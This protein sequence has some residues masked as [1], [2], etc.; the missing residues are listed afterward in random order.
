MKV[1]VTG[2]GGFLGCHI[3]ALLQQ[4]GYQVRVMS[5]SRQPIFEPRGIECMRG[6]ISYLEEVEAA[7]K[8]MD[9]V[10]NVAGRASID[11][12]YQAYYNTHVIGAKNIVRACKRFGVTRL[13]HTSTP[14]VVFNGKDLSGG[15]ESLPNQK[16]YH[17]YY[18]STK[19][20]AEEYILGCNSEDLRTVALRPHLILGEGDPH[21][22]PR[23][24]ESVRSGEFRMI[25][26]GKNW[27]D[28]TFVSN[29]AHAHLLAFDALDTGK[30]CGKAY[31]IGQERPI[32]LW[33]FINTILSHLNLP[34]VTKRVS[35]GK[36]YGVGMLMEC[37]YKTFCRSRMPPM[38]RALAVALSHDH[39]FSHER[40]RND[41]GY[42]PP[43]TIEQGLTN[44]VNGLQLQ[45]KFLGRPRYKLD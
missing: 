29:A 39:Y 45:V 31:F 9:A 22:M 1:L 44:L 25:G 19:A 8:G 35:F 42:T 5:R 2:G 24:I 30:A 34:E 33:N 20:M 13:V 26:D 7:V 10:F 41:L 21:L 28:I 4:R 40:A 16:N 11:M 23:I 3:V 32:N 18:A 14:A 15:D 37:F 17:W 38:T 36:A 12:N 27:V 6:D 43:V